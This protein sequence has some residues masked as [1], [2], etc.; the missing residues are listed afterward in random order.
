ML[1]DTKLKKSLGK[2]RD[3]IEIISDSHGLNARIS[4]AGKITFFYRYRWVKEPVQLSI[5][6]YPAM[7]IAQARERRQVLRGWLTEGFDPREKIR[8]ERLSRNASPTVDEAFNYWIDKYCRP[9]GSVKI[10]YYLQV[11]CK[12]IKPKLG[13]LRM[14]STARMHWLEV[15]DAIESSVMANYMTS[16]C[17]R[18][19]KFCVNRGYI[20]ANPLEG[21]GPRDVGTAPTR[22]KRYLADREIRQTWQWLDNHQTDE[23]RLIIRFMLLT[24]CRTAEIRRACW[25]WFDFEDDTWTVPKEEYKTGVAVRRA[26]PPLAKALLLTHREKVNTRHV[27]T[28]QRA[29]PG[30]EF[31]R[32]VQPQVAANYTRR[33]F[34][35]TGMKPWSMHDLR[36]TLA[37]KLSEQGAPPHV[38]EKILGH[39]MTG[40]MAHYNL[41]DYMDDQRHWLGVWEDYVK[42]VTG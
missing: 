22:K 33:V 17:K 37:T 13:E 34:E 15:L 16:L 6:E 18:A 24:G 4:K 30:K 42:G 2:K 23:A 39:L 11:Y 20:A 7:T 27:V 5:G 14:E 36:R 8:L 41:H 1:T 12:H 31:D 35:G 26:L 19:F 21:L 38:I 28:S 29:M 32:P 10:D 40:T 25:D 9:N 3:A